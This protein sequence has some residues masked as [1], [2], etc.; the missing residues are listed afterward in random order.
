[1]SNIINLNQN[2]QP[3]QEPQITPE[4]LEQADDLSCGSCGGIFISTVVNYKRIN[5]ILIGTPQDYLIPT[6]VHRCSDCGELFDMNE[7]IERVSK[8]V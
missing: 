4:M 2:S 5:K 1:M 6:P 3:P 7:A 8:K